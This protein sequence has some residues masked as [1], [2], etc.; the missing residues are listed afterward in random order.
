MLSGLLELIQVQMRRVSIGL[1]RDNLSVIS[2]VGT[3]DAERGIGKDS[4][5]KTSAIGVKGSVHWQ[6]WLRSLLLL[7]PCFA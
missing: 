5:S 2:L 1:D 6:A 4:V 3:C 7:I